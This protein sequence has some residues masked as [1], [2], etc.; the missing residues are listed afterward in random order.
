MNDSTLDFLA[1]NLSKIET[2][3][4]G[5]PRI[6]QRS[7]LKMKAE[8]ILLLIDKA[9][10]AAFDMKAELIRSEV[11]LSR[12]EIRKRKGSETGGRNDHAI[13]LAVSD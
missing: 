12:T 3:A 1:V 8:E 10:R 6:S 2:I 9:R 11:R 4:G 5:L 7:G 13:F